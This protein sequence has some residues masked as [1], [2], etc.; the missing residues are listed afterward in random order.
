MTALLLHGLG[1]DRRQPLELLAPPL[2]GVDGPEVRLIATDARAHGDSPRIGEAH[3][4]ALD[5][6]AEEAVADA[7]ALE[8]G[9]AEGPV[10]LLGISMG[11]ALA[12]RIAL[13]GLLPVDRAVFV[14]PSFDD[15]PYPEHLRPFPVIGQLLH[16]RGPAAV[17]DFR[18]SW[19]YRTVEHRSPAGARALL[20]QFGS[21]RAA[22]RAVRLVEVPRNRAFS[23]DAELAG[24]P[25]AGIRSLVVAAERDPVH[26][27]ELGERW[28][29]GLRAELV[30]APPREDGIPA[31][32]ARIREG[33]ARWL[34]ANPPRR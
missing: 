11:A 7:L 4:F 30:V 24:L 31:L 19:H 25:E 14:R 16:D 21:P 10:T 17:E 32:S 18:E 8:P 26:P 13:R 34:E 27:V 6:L 22:E 33:V 15:T 1:A 9:L 28:A 20:S 5:R 3:D 23:G 29:A 2:I 12:L